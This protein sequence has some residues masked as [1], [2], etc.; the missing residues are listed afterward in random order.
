MQNIGVL[1]QLELYICVLMAIFNLFV[2]T[3][4]SNVNFIFCIERGSVIHGSG[5][6]PLSCSDS[7][8]DI[9]VNLFISPQNFFGAT[10]F[11]HELLLCKND[12]VG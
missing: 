12:H 6:W 3:L 11:A 7:I 2:T 5:G 10:M 9:K 1:F 8:K 4:H